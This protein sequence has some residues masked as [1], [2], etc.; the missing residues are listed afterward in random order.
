MSDHVLPRR[1]NAYLEFARAHPELF[2]APVGELRILLDP[3]E[4]RGVER[5][6]ARSLA[7]RGLPASQ[8]QVGIVFEDPWFFIL[9]DA[10]EFPDGSRRTHTR[11]FNRV[12]N[13]SAVLPVLEGRIVLVRQFRHPPRRWLL[14]IPRGAIEPGQTPEDAA[15]A[16]LREE[17]G[18]EVLRLVPLGFVYGSTHLYHNGAHLFYAE[19]ES[20]GAPQLS[21]GI[22]AV[23]QVSVVRFEELLRGGELL[24]AITLAAFAHARVRGLV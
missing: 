15:R 2:D 7:R 17:A 11:T 23:E 19:L 10:V 6:V 8:A 16:E 18:G 20:V 12:G 9:R 5:T 22:T 14:E 24:D 13:G 1:L 21:E 3:A 4:I